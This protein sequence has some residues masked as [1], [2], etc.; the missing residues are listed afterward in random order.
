M[1]EK[2]RS[3]F[4]ELRGAPVAREF[5]PDDYRVAAAA[6]LVHLGHADGGLDEEEMAY[7]R[8]VASESF[9]L[10]ADKAERLIAYAEEEERNAIDLNQFTSTLKRNLDEEGRRIIVELL[11]QMAYADGAAH[12]FEDNLVWRVSELL[13]VST[14]DRL[15]LRRRV[16]DGQV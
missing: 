15:S 8:R 10:D 11:W 1:F 14:Q 7:L 12:E 9:G 6:L 3:L 5:Q 4:D 2:I 16:R 13:G